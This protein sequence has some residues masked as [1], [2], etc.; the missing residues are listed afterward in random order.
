MLC[1]ANTCGC[2]KMARI[3][4]D[5]HNRKWRLPAE[6]RDAALAI[7]NHPLRHQHSGGGHPPCL[8]EKFV[9][10]KKSVLVLQMTWRI[11][12][13]ANL[14]RK[15]ITAIVAASVAWKALKRFSREETR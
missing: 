3:V 1:F 15:V 7:V 10:L 14:T 5:T 11:L 12:Y 9:S 4:N 8:A 6:E 2:K 13:A